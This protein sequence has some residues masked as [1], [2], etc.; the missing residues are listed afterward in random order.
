MFNIINML[1]NLFLLKK[2]EKRQ[3]KVGWFWVIFPPTTIIAVILA[4][5]IILLFVLFR[6]IRS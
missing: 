2:V 3:G 1:I 6:W 4:L 5:I